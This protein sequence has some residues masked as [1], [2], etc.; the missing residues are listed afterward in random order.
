MHNRKCTSQILHVNRSLHYW[1]RKCAVRML[2][3]L[4][5]LIFCL[6]HGLPVS[7]VLVSFCK[8]IRF[9]SSK[10]ES[11][12]TSLLVVRPIYCCFRKAELCL[13][14][15]PSHGGQ[16]KY[17]GV[18]WQGW[19]PAPGLGSWSPVPC[20]KASGIKGI[21]WLQT[22]LA[23]WG[24]Q[25][26]WRERIYWHAHHHFLGEFLTFFKGIPWKLKQ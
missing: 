6:L 15:S 8:F 23:L 14:L 21:T 1:A 11:E 20:V 17:S 3:S 18:D 9:A 7:L 25:A 12:I 13:C 26:L 2:H 24:H 22:E 19:Q 16:M 5:V 4:S 10:S